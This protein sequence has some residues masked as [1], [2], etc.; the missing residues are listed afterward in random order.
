MVSGP[1]EDRPGL[2]ETSAPIPSLAIAESDAAGGKEDPDAAIHE[3]LANC[4]TKQT[5]LTRSGK[6]SERQ[7]HR[8]SERLFICRS[9]RSRP[10][11]TLADDP[12][13]T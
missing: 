6:L 1:K 4:E 9:S 7:M 5:R 10:L 3:G 13:G 11:A 12:T 8:P 2:R